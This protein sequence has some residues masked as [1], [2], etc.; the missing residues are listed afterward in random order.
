[1]PRLQSGFGG[2]DETWWAQGARV[3][4]FDHNNIDNG[5]GTHV[6][7]LSGEKR[8]AIELTDKWTKLVSRS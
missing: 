6:R 3:F 7:F 1:M 5:V 8:Y 4:T 2:Y